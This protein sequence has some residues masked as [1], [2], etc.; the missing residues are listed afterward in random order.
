MCPL[1][2]ALLGNRMDSSALAPLDLA[3]AARLHSWDWLFELRRRLNVIAEIVDDRGTPALPVS[4]VTTAG[5][6]LA[7]PGNPS[8]RSAI[9]KAIQL[10]LPQSVAVDQYVVACFPLAP[11]RMAS[12]ALLLAR[13]QP[14]ESP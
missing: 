11:G 14:S 3:T 1:R 12:G 4:P 9:A 7:R 5:R 10:K 13:D 8:L 2:L 6:L